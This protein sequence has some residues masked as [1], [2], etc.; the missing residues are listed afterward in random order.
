M[1]IQ[2]IKEEAEAEEEE[3]GKEGRKE[4]WQVGK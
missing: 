4:E 3:K 2:M 1:V